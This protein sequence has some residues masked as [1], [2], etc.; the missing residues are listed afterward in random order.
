MGNIGKG[1]WSNS[2][3]EYPSIRA[4]HRIDF[5]KPELFID[6]DHAMLPFL[7]NCAELFFAFLECIFRL[8]PVGD[9]TDRFNRTD[10]R[11]LGIIERSDNEPEIGTFPPIESLD[12]NL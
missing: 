5:E 3:F 12:I 6:H 1:L 7:K 4:E 10:D 8:F 9:I 11:A 2:S